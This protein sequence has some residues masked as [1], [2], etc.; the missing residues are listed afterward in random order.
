M[1]MVATKRK[2]ETSMGFIN[3]EPTGL[4]EK[5]VTNGFLCLQKRYRFRIEGFFEDGQSMRVV[6]QVD[7]MDWVDCMDPMDGREKAG[8]PVQELR[9]E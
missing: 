8:A 9:L 1:A 3:L 6:G 5:N 7:E 2:M 4:H